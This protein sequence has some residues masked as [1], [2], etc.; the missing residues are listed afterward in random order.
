MCATGVRCIPGEINH[1]NAQHK[2]KPRDQEGDHGAIILRG[3]SKDVCSV[4]LRLACHNKASIAKFMTKMVIIVNRKCIKI[5]F[6][7]NDVEIVSTDA[8]YRPKKQPTAN[9]KRKRLLRLLERGALNV[10]SPGGF[11]PPSPP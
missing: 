1:C 8:R 6:L 4:Y 9:L 7:L 11:E 2:K 3:F 10:A 5:A